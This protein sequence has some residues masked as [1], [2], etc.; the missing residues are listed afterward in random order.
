MNFNFDN[1]ISIH[2]KQLVLGLTAFFLSKFRF[3]ELRKSGV[4]S[5]G[6]PGMRK[7]KPPEM[8]MVKYIYAFTGN[9]AVHFMESGTAPLRFDNSDTTLRQDGDNLLLYCGYTV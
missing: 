6:V 5:H 7:V 8:Y 9:K 1:F 3:G 2:T 4:V